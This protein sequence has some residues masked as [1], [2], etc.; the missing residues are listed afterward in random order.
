MLLTTPNAFTKLKGEL[1][2]FGGLLCRDSL[3][4]SRS[5]QST[6]TFTRV[7]NVAELRHIRNKRGR[8]CAIYCECVQRYCRVRGEMWTDIETSGRLS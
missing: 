8:R 6:V 7:I 4:R 2:H 1:P 5:C 3:P